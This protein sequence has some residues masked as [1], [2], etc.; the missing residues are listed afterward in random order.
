MKKFI[1][2]AV[3]AFVLMMT[4]PG[5]AVDLT[6]IFG[7]GGFVGYAFGIGDTFD[8]VDFGNGSSMQNK[9]QFAFGGDLRYNFTPEMGVMGSVD[10]QT[11]KIDFEGESAPSD[12]TEDWICVSGY[13]T[14]TLMLEGNTMPYGMVGPAIYI[15]SFDNADTKLG[16]NAGAGVLHFFNTNM[17]LDAGLK[18]HYIPAF[19]EDGNSTTALQPFVGFSYFFNSEI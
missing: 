15:P 10:Y 17:A 6:G 11:W 12:E 9:L 13:F 8:K 4:V 16:F 7:A 5:F 18:V 14:Y 3:V 19:Y 1:I 2:G